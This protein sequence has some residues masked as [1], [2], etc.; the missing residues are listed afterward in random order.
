M[1]TLSLVHRVRLP[2]L[3]P[4]RRAPAIVMLHGLLGNEQVMSIFDRLVPPGVMIVAPRAPFGAGGDS[5]EWYGRDDAA[6]SF[7]QGL[8][9][10]RDFVRALPEAYPMD[11]G[12][13]LLMGFSQGAAMSFAL[14][15][16]EPQSARA[17][18]AMAG[19]LPGP[20]RPWLRPGRLSGKAIFI[21]HGRDDVTVP[22]ARAQ[23]ARDDL[24]AAGAEVVYHEYD[25]GHKMNAR[26]MAA[27]RQW[28]GVQVERWA[29]EGGG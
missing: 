4:G 8:G 20:A 6:R 27:L 9:A 29:R 15:L 13:V 3:A 21:A 1:P 14:L 23:A 19:F 22:L 17:V 24:R 7:E 10:L 12:Q 28:L 25:T 16:S 26:G 2:D 11:A 18:A 5:F